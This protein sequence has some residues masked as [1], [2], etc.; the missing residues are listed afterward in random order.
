MIA[1][2]VLCAVAN[3]QYTDNMGYKWNNPTSA[4]I[5]NIIND[6]LWNRLRAKARARTRSS[7]PSRAETPASEPEVSK[8]T[9]AQI[10]AA[11][12]FR[13]T[14]TQIKTRAFADAL[15][16]GVAE[17]RQQMTDLITLLLTEY[18]KATRAQGK[19]NDL[20]LAVTAALVYN[21]SIYNGT[22]E[23]DDA[24]IMEIRDALAELAA[25]DG[26]FAAMTDR[27]KQELYE[28][29]V[30]STMLAKVG[31]E[32]A[33]KSGDAATAKSYRDLAGETLRLVSGLP[34]EKVDLSSDTEAVNAAKMLD[35]LPNGPRTVPPASQGADFLDGDPFPDKP[36]IQP[37]KPLIGQLRKTIT[38]ADLAGKW[39]IGGASV[40]EYVSS[41]TQSQT[42]VSFGR[43]DYVIRAD[44]GY[45][46]KFQG[47]ASNTTIRESESGTIILSGGYIIKRDSK[48]REIKYQFVAFMEQS[49]HSA[50]L[51]LI[52]LGDNPPLNAESLRANCAHANGY[53]SC[54]NGEEWVRLP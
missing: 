45:T 37:Q 35:A 15:S 24:R 54:L 34:P 5:G 14:G 6:R 44:G 38:L 10:G 2:C 8:K 40:M 30:I 23:P 48:G 36:Y 53:V 39:E 43:T 25:E 19:P 27:Q 12:T 47:R 9:P 50:V 18:E 26:T 29:L 4:S 46:G 52:Y 33:K 11:V 7:A 20:A 31:Y 1:L 51:S 13:S 49:N 32:E 3:A 28:N 21:S 17:T 41:S 42:S 16:G 22:A